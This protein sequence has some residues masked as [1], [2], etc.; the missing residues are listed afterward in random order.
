[1]PRGKGLSDVEKGQIDVLYQDGKSQREIAKRIGNRSRNAVYNYIHSANKPNIEQRGRKRKLSDRDERSV[2]RCA[3][4]QSLSC[5]EIAVECGLAV[6]RMTIDRTLQRNDLKYAKLQRK[7]R[8]TKAHKAARSAFANDYQTWR[9]E[10]E[11]VIWSDEKR[12][13]LD[14]P[15]GWCHYWHDLRKEPVILA[16]ERQGGG[17]MI[18]AGFGPKGKT[19]VCFCQG[20]MTSKTYQNTL[21]TTLIPVAEQICGENY[22]FQQDNAPIHVSESTMEFF[23]SNKIQ[24]FPIPP[25]SPDL[26]PIENVWGLLARRVYWGGNQY[27][28]LNELKNA[29]ISAWNSITVAELQPFIES[30]P[31]RIFELIAN[32]GSSTRF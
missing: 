26:N 10:W 12:F 11:N 6:N 1:M 14:G 4:N 5:R 24:L 28:N 9:K 8:L 22:L 27:N 32:H 7:P 17:V 31:N 13:N 23:E 25:K 16:K 3:S 21:R 2:V 15:D 29:I 30:M 19:D 20:S 18:W